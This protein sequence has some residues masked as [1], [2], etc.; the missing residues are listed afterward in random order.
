[1]QPLLSFLLLMLLGF[2]PFYTH[3]THFDGGPID[4]GIF[5][6]VLVHG[7]S[8]AAWFLLFL[9]QSLLIAF[10]TASCI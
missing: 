6:L 9:A 10:G 1:M 8:I 7:V 2:R 3:G 4:R 5:L